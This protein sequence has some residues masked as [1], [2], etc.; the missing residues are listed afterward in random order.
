MSQTTI[1]WGDGRAGIKFSVAT[2]YQVVTSSFW[3]RNFISEDGSKPLHRIVDLEKGRGFDQVRV[4]KWNQLTEPP[5]IGD[6]RARGKEEGLQ[7]TF[8]QMW[9]NQAR[10]PV[11]CG[12]KMS[13]K[14]TAHDLREVARGRHSV[15]WSRWFDEEFFVYGA[16]RRGNG[17]KNWLHSLTWDFSGFANNTLAVPHTNNIFYPSGISAE[18]AITAANGLMSVGLMEYWDYLIDQMDNPP[19]PLIINGEETYIVIMSMYDRYA[20]RTGT[21]NVNSA[22]GDWANM[23]K[24]GKKESDMPWA[25]ILGKWGR[26]L[27]FAHNK[28]VRYYHANNNNQTGGVVND[29]LIVGAQALALAHGDAG[30]GM[31]FWWH[32]EPIDYNNEPVIVTG[33]MFG[34]QRVDFETTPGTSTTKAPHGLIVA[35]TFGGTSS[36]I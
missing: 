13:Q 21:S 34:I 31:H 32:E 4:D 16:G 25:G 9:I 7:G 29:C 20:L 23:K 36:S 17:T 5:V 26:F 15:F 8:L 1:P 2:A 14:R 3:G 22:I 10:K 19:E 27:L 35:K 30:E 18:T 12:G 28:V 33:T 11:S 6:A 24:Y